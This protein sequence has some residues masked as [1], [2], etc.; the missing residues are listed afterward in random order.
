MMIVCFK[1]N[2]DT[3]ISLIFIAAFYTTDY[4]YPVSVTVPNGR[5]ILA[6][7]IREH[8]PMPAHDVIDSIVDCF[9]ERTLAAGAYFL[10]ARSYSHEYMFLAGGFMR[11]FTHD[12][13]GNEVTTA[14]CP[15]GG[16][17]FEIASFFEHTRSMES[18]QALTD[19]TGYVLQFDELNRLFHAYP[20]FRKFGRAMLVKG[21]AALK[22]RTLSLINETA[23][24]R[25]VRLLQTHPEIFMHAPLKHIA[26]YLGITDTSLSRIRKA[27]RGK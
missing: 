24:A 18:I 7:F 16:V 19:C 10:Q 12:T 1:K 21:F 22:Q 15:A 14:F 11:V 2:N 17:V 27:W 25:Y 20:E 6:R 13:E 23:E 8:L 4:L 26:T 5:E 3:L 9:E